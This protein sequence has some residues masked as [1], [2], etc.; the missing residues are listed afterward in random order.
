MY[1]VE[2]IKAKCS[3]WPSDKDWKAS[4]DKVVTALINSHFLIKSRSKYVA[5]EY[6]EDKNIVIP[7]K[8]FTTK[9]KGREYI[10]RGKE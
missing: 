2:E 7:V 8:V 1:S 3:N 4:G 6:N 10:R 9:E 5:M